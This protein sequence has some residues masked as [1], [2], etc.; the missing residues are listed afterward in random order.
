MIDW[1]IKL[2]VDGFCVFPLHRMEGDGLVEPMACSCGRP[3]LSPGK[4]PRTPNGCKDATRDEAQIAAW[5]GRWPGANIG[6]A[7]GTPSA[8]Y[9]VDLDGTQ[10]METWRAL[11]IP[12]P[13]R[14]AATGSGGQH[15]YFG[16]AEGETL[17]NTAG[18]LGIKVD[19][20]GTGGYV[21]APPSNHKSGGVYQW[22]ARGELTPIPA[23][24]YA[25]LAPQSSTPLGVPT[26]SDRT[27]AYGQG[28][29]V[30]ACQ[31]IG[32]APEGT[33]N[34]TLNDEAFL[35]GQFVGGGE[36]DPC[37]VEQLLADACRGPDV[38]KNVAT[39]RRGLS[40]GLHHPKTK[41]ET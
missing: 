1:A 32:A 10:G 41:A 37:G 3:C 6:I 20:R 34:Q 14:I 9:V 33:R 24:L 19:T 13:A 40:A 17:P 15:L 7:T 38:K 30:H 29:L 31:R 2:A 28:V 21:V 23:A 8:C 36:I 22:L 11:G 39:V 25:L 16:L 5:W 35:V 27:S 4:H 18:R 26:L 12:D